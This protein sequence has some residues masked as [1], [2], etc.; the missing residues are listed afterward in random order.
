MVMY[1]AWLRDN[2]SHQFCPAQKSDR[3]ILS[4]PRFA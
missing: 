3:A 2:T 4:Q 1:A